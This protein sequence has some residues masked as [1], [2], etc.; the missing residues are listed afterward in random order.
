MIR[1]SVGSVG[2]WKDTAHPPPGCT[3]RAEGRPMSSAGRS[4]RPWRSSWG[5]SP[6]PWNRS[7]HAA[8]GPNSRRFP[9][10]PLHGRPGLLQRALKLE[11]IVR[12]FP[13]GRHELVGHR[14]ELLLFLLVEVELLLPRFAVGNV[15]A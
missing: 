8:A 6:R 14:E 12:R 2:F 7:R 1:V 11:Q 4:P 9:P 13:R 10:P 15:I 3:E 5:R